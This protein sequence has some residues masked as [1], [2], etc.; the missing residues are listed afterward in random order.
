MTLETRQAPEFD[1]DYSI[2]DFTPG[3][4]RESQYLYA[5]IE[6]AV[7]ELATEFPYG[8][9]LDVACGTGKQAMRIAAL[10]CATV[11]I[12]AS[13]GMIGVGRW[14][15]PES[16]AVMVR[17][18]A[19]KLPFA[20]GT[21]DRVVCQ[22]A[23]DHF[24][25]P[26]AFMREA[27]RITAPYGRVV[28]AITNFNSVSCRVGRGAD[29]LK[30]ALR[31]PR[32]PWRMYWQTPEDHTVF[33]DMPFVRSLGGDALELERCFGVAM[34]SLNPQYAWLLDRLPERM[35]RGLWR[36]LDGYAR[37]RPT[38]ADTIFSVWRRKDTRA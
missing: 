30:R 7:L 1:L 36:T 8:R 5:A 32:P 17:S 38:Q 13:A 9:V 24:A 29:R 14:L 23:L 26:H 18:I 19:E 3:T 37:T 31:R 35:A 2:D 22:G 28:I 12:E 27:A 11:G 34:M 21:F 25:D 16:E 10:G 15:H 20:D 6:D 33:G 4:N